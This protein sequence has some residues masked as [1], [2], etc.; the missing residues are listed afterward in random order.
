MSK[1]D[2]LPN[3]YSM[4]CT[5]DDVLQSL[6]FQKI[7]VLNVA[8]SEMYTCHLDGN[9]FGG[10]AVPENT[11]LKFYLSEMVIHDLE[12]TYGRYTPQLRHD[13]LPVIQDIY[14][15]Y[16]EEVLRSLH[17][18]I[19]IC[20]RETRHTNEVFAN[21]VSSL[22]E[23]LKAL[24]YPSGHPMYGSV[25]SLHTCLEGKEFFGSSGNAATSIV[26]KS[27]PAGYTLDEAL[28]YCQCVFDNCTFPSAS[29]GGA[30][31]LNI[32]KVARDIAS[33]SVS[34]YVGLDMAFSLTHNCGSIYNK[35]FLYYDSAN[36]VH[37]T[38]LL[39]VQRSGQLMNAI[40]S[41][42]LLNMLE[43][44][45]SVDTSIA[46]LNMDEETLS[47]VL[48]AVD[49]LFPWVR[50]LNRL[51]PEEY[52]K[53]F[54]FVKMVEAGC[55]GSYVDQVKKESMHIVT[56]E[57][58]RAAL[59]Q[60]FGEGYVKPEEVLY[61]FDPDIEAKVNPKNSTGY[62]GLQLNLVGKQ[63]GLGF[64]LPELKPA[65]VLIRKNLEKE[66]V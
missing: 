30:A 49:G 63:T 45:N 61:Q 59:D 51:N 50:L 19:G 15:F 3:A 36:A 38:F 39:D 16:N 25:L 13:V 57:H 44:R 21:R 29:F 23:G 5:V 37:T 43:C 35:G 11:I 40:N 53:P 28:T 2:L 33:G 60:Y 41:Q 14:A 24:G 26:L 10:K 6:A 64:I 32:T 34:L 65:P 31:W 18:L 55:E 48:S 66:N 46:P 20:L 42:Y 47:S 52:A 54:S 12:R 56:G 9:S 7:N 8:L 17:Y 22:K 27:F 1:K 4:V 58:A 62:T